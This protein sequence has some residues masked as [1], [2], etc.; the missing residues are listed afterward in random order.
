M[1][2]HKSKTTKEGNGVLK[3]CVLKL[4]EGAT[5]FGWIALGH[6][7]NPALR[8]SAVSDC[9]L[10][11][12]C[13]GPISVSEHNATRARGLRHGSMPSRIHRVGCFAALTKGTKIQLSCTEVR[14]ATLTCVQVLLYLSKKSWV[15]SSHLLILNCCELNVTA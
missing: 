2:L 7:S 11:L 13:V 15:V 9:A 3:N 6:R 1:L 5:I 8:P 12:Y 10:V 4:S 14:S